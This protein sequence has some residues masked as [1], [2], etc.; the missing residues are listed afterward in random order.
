VNVSR[1]LA[2]AAAL[3][4]AGE[5]AVAADAQT[6][7]LEPLA[8]LAGHCFTGKSAN[9]KDVDEHCFQWLLGGKALRDAHVVR[10]PGHADYHGETTYYWDSIARRIQYL[11]IESDGGLMSG[12]V[13]P[14]HEAL[15]FPAS[16]FIEN[17]KA[18]T[19]RVR[20]TLLPDGG[21]EAWSEVQ[22]KGSWRTM[23]RMKMVKSS[24]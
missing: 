20:W 11:Y 4:F 2:A 14:A 12:S 17:G 22:D 9:G 5:V 10:G 18:L 21:Y 1:S 23:F 19:L 7:P 15:M 13:V 3:A 24:R 16:S 8:F 6:N